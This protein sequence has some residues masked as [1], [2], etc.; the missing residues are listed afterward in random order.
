MTTIYTIKEFPEALHRAAKVRA[1]IEGI[2]LKQ[3]IL[4]ALTEYLERAGRKGG[5]R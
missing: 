3:L 4:K 5:G 2:T 1:A